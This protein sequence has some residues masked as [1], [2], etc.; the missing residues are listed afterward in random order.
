MV[1]PTTVNI[2]YCFDSISCMVLIL[3]GTAFCSPAPILWSRLP[4]HI[5]R[6]PSLGPFK[7]EPQRGTP[8]F[9]E[10]FCVLALPSFVNQPWV[11]SCAQGA[12]NVCILMC[13]YKARHENVQEV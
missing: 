1:V 3:R 2:N 11:S 7:N 5:C 8:L 12:L 9:T 6:A 4:L 10:T 13:L